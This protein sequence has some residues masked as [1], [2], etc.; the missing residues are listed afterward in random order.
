M[1]VVEKMKRVILFG[2]VFI[3]LGCGNEGELIC[4]EPPPCPECECPVVECPVCQCRCP[5]CKNTTHIIDNQDSTYVTNLIRQ[6]KACEKDQNRNWSYIQL[7]DDWEECNKTLSKIK[8]E[9][10]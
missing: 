3:L 7:M 8:E 5:E 9:L 1:E 10:E 2:L 6:L 4:P